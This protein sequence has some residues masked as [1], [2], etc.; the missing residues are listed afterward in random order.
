M[1]SL[2]LGIDSRYRKS[3]LLSSPHQ[4]VCPWITLKPVESVLT[5]LC[6]YDTLQN[7]W[8]KATVVSLRL[9]ILFVT[10]QNTNSLLAQLLDRLCLWLWRI[11]KRL[12]VRVVIG[13]TT[14]E[15]GRELVSRAAESMSLCPTTWEAVPLTLPEQRK[16]GGRSSYWSNNSWR[17]RELVSRATESMSLSPTT[18]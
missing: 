15:K 18:Q 8:V 3:S 2:L 1:W 9:R 6:G 7:S 14:P 13:L 11:K 10:L 4:R 16:V 5:F 17:S 12:V